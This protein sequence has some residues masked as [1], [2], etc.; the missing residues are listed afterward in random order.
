MAYQQGYIYK[1][2]NAWH[3]R[4]YTTGTVKGVKVRVQKSRRICDTKDHSKSDA[5]RLAA[6]FLADLNEPV[7]ADATVDRDTTVSE[8]W[9]KVYEPFI[10]ENKHASTVHGYCQ[11]W[12]QHLKP[13]LGDRTLKEYRTPMG[14]VFLTGLA[15]KLR[16]YTVQHIRSLASG[17]F[18]HAVAVGAVESNPWHDVKILGKVKG[19]G[20]TP[21][22]TLE[23][24]EDIVS[25]LADHPEAQLIVCL[26]Y[27][28]GLRPSEI[29]ALDWT[30]FDAQC[31]HVRRA[32]GRGVVGD[33][34]SEK[35]VRSVPIIAQVRIPLELWRKKRG[36]PTQGWVFPNSQGKPV[37]LR[38]LTDRVIVPALEANKI[39]WRGLY[40]C[41]RGFAT[42][43]TELT[44]D[45]G[46]AASQ[47]LGHSD[48]KVT[49]AHYIKPIPQETIEAMKMLEERAGRS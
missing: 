24:V 49:L 21:H 7:A 8:F 5:K 22:Y 45:R 6:P 46:L 35:S 23:Q 47:A 34:K 38:K 30:D 3:L 15:K 16:F 25:A 43:I 11:I 13:H 20:T 4:Y 14:T 10:V 19:K 48:P 28:A 33:T 41:R 12:K 27:F 18:S 29:G 44:K 37:D 26:A 31:V 1:A 9:E 32:I 2:F 42:I 39:E 17:I 40:A 36:M